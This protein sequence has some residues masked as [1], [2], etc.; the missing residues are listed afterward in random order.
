FLRGGKAAGF[1][2]RWRTDCRIRTQRPTL[3]LGRR[4]AANPARLRPPIGVAAPLDILA[5]RAS[6]A[7][8]SA[9][10]IAATSATAGTAAGIG[11]VAGWPA[12][13]TN[14]IISRSDC[15]L[16]ASVLAATAAR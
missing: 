6:R 13:P 4:R 7:R 11:G 14:P 1:P 16:L 15:A 2:R 8:Q 9:A 12:T 3:R 10:S 5:H